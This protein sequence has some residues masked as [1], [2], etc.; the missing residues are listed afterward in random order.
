MP[1]ANLPAASVPAI[2]SEPIYH[3]SRPVFTFLLVKIVFSIVKLL[4]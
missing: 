1:A 4:T 2:V 3:I